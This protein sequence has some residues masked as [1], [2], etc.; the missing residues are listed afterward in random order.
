MRTTSWINGA[1]SIMAQQVN[2]GN[3]ANSTKNVI[4]AKFLSFPKITSIE[5]AQRT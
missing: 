5:E 4:P 1:G 2:V 3:N